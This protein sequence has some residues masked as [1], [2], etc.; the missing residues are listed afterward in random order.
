MEA[1]SYIDAHDFAVATVQGA[2]E[3]ARAAFGN[4]VIQ[5]KKSDVAFDV[6]TGADRDIDTYIKNSI[7]AK[8]PLHAQ[9]SEE[10]GAHGM[11]EYTWTVDPID[12]SSNFSRGIPH[13]AIC[14][15][16]LHH[17]VSV[18]GA[19]FNPI[20]KEL[21]SFWQGGGVFLNGVAIKASG[22]D[23]L[24]GGQVLFTMSS[25]AENLDWGLALYRKL[26]E[27]DSRV[28]NFGASSLDL[29]FLAAGRVDAVV[30]GGLSLRDISPA[31]GMVREVC[32]D[33]YA[34]NTGVPATFEQ[35]PQKIVATMTPTLAQ[36]IRRL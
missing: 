14:V 5:Y 23:T 12:G 15:G 10:S 6:V 3:L 2:G 31:L 32:G 7:A 33:V 25:R 35:A 27:A 20:T 30:Y 22:R 34:F 21:F 17:N 36:S 11:S 26:F 16:L 1:I 29:C 4:S 8:Y 19:V 9:Y 24:A 28:R 13:F 18:A